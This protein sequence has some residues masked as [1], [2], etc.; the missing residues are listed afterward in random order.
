MPQTPWLC[1]NSHTSHAVLPAWLHRYSESRWLAVRCARGPPLLCCPMRT[2]TLPASPSCARTCASVTERPPP[3]VTLQLCLMELGHEQDSKIHSAMVRR[4]PARCP[5]LSLSLRRRDAR[6]L[7]VLD[8]GTGARPST[9]TSRRAANPQVHLRHALVHADQVSGGRALSA[10]AGALHSAS[11]MHHVRPEK[12]GP[13][14]RGAGC[15][16]SHRA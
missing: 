2:W 5:A 12:G 8:L 13:R 11:I 9:R 4:L 15:G 14:A 10:R 1:P 16:A 3:R 6:E 7:S